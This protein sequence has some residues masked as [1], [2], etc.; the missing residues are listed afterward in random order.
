MASCFALFI[1]GRSNFVYRRRCW[2]LFYRRCRTYFLQCT[3]CSEDGCNGP[4]WNGWCLR[5]RIWG[6]L[7]LLFHKKRN[8][9]EFIRHL[10][11][12]EA[13]FTLYE[14]SNLACPVS[15]TNFT[16]CS[17]VLLPR[18]IKWRNM[19]MVWIAKRKEAKKAPPKFVCVYPCFVSACRLGVFKTRNGEMANRRNGEMR[20][21]R[22]KT[23]YHLTRVNQTRKRY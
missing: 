16:T 21:K 14:P 5:W 13:L 22:Y 10:S 3:G 17:L 19:N 9:N 8:N 4:G 11:Y 15:E 6:D 7:Q 23:L 2:R 20:Y 18:R 12:H 1:A